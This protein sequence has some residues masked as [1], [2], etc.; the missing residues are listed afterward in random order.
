[1]PVY[2]LLISAGGWLALW[3]LIVAPFHWNKTDHGIAETEERE[4][5]TSLSEV[6]LR[7]HQ[8]LWQRRIQTG[9]PLA[10]GM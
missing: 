3:Q 10:R 9:D 7:G 5:P 6:D 4:T 1:M 2:W 8:R